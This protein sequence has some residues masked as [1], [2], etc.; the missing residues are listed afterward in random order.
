MFWIS[1]GFFMGLFLILFIGNVYMLAHNAHPN[2]TPMGK[3]I[4]MRALVVFNYC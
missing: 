3:N 1:I 2:D 4:F